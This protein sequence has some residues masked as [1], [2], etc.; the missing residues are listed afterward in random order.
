MIQIQKNQKDPNPKN[1]NDP[2][3]EK[4]ESPNPK[5]KPATKTNQN[6]IQSLKKP[7]ILENQV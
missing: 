3:P 1:Q 4:P 2:D 7:T 5:K 6:Q